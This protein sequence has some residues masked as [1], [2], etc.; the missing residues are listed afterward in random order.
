MYI[1][2]YKYIVF[3]VLYLYVC[4][5]VFHLEMSRKFMK[6]IHLFFF[7][8]LKSFLKIIFVFPGLIKRPILY[9]TVGYQKSPGSLFFKTLNRIYSLFSDYKKMSYSL[10]VSPNQ[11]ASNGSKFIFLVLIYNK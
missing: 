2:L 5:C 3:Y 1:Y 9:C 8:T 10:L 7:L 11:N 4:V 6:N